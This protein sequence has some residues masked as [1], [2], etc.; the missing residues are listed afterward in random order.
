MIPIVI[1]GDDAD[2]HRRRSFMVLTVGSL[3]ATGNMFDTKLLCYV[4]D[5]SR[6]TSGTVSTLDKWISWSLLE[7]Q[8]GI[9]LDLDPWGRPYP[10]HSAG[11]IGSIMDGWRAVLVCHKGDEKYIQ[12]VYKTSHGAVSKNICILCEASNECGSQMLYTYHGATAPHRA[13]L[14][15]TSQFI[16]KV[17]GVDSWVR[18]PGWH[19][20]YVQL[21]WLHVMDLTII[22]EC[23]GSALQELVSEQYWPGNTADE[24]LRRGF[25]SFSRACKFAKVKNRGLMFSMNP[26]CD[27]V[28]CCFVRMVCV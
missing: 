14:F 18:M 5:N 17:A 28:P 1:H 4:L 9:F 20:R 24:R 8:L 10:R 27:F 12:K 22:P 2:S 15:S 26:A 11:R 3:L 25:V 16:E 7:L 21:D 23:A 13:T 6:T 19:I